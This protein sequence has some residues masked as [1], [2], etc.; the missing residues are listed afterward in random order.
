[1][2]V[3]QDR[4]PRVLRGQEPAV[5]ETAVSLYERQ[6]RRNRSG[7]QYL[8]TR[9][10]DRRTTTELRVGY[11]GGGLERELR[12]AKLDR[13][14]AEDLGLLSGSRDTLAERI[15]IPD[16]GAGGRPTWLTGRALAAGATPRYLNVRLP[17]PLLGLGSVAGRRAAIVATEGPFDWLTLRSWGLRGVALVG[18]HVSHDAML[19]LARFQRVYLALDGDGAGRR[20][21]AGLVAQLRDR[22][23]IVPLPAGAHDL[24]ELGQRHDGRDAFLRSLHA[25]R[26][27]L[28]DSWQSQTEHDRRSRAA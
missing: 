25:S 12:R 13:R 5:L 27:R 19:A 18:T 3:R 9:G 20:A 11:A 17:S 24:N 21:A 15:V 7:Q 10:I 8:K 4:E 2:P 26:E 1:L 6:L 23:V 14:V 22:A 28:D 16:L